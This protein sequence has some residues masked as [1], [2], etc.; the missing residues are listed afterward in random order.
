MR[1]VSAKFIGLK[2][3]YSKSGI[4]TVDIDFTKCKHNI[5]MITGKNGSGKSTLL[6]VLT[7]LPDSPQMYLDHRLGSKEIVY[8]DG[9]N[10]YEINIQYP[11][12]SNGTRLATKAFF[13]E[14]KNNQSVE[15][16]PNGTLGSY[17]DILFNKFNLDANYISL[18]KL[19]M[20]DRGIVDKRPSERKKYVGKMLE[21]VEAYNDIYKTLVKRSSIFKSMINSITAKIDSIGDEQKLTMEINAINTR[22]S[23]LENEK[24]ILESSISASNA[25]VA[26]YDPNNSIQDTYN[27]CIRELKEL[28]SE[29]DNIELSIST[30][31]SKFDIDL[32][33]ENILKKYKL[34]ED[35]KTATL[36]EIELQK[37]K[38]QYTLANR[39]E[40]A[41]QIEI[42]RQKLLTQQSDVDISNL[43][44]SIVEYRKKIFEYEKTFNTI[45]I[46][47][48]EISK[49]EYVLGLNTLN[50]LRNTVLN[51]KSYADNS[52]IIKIC[53]Y[54][55]TEKNPV[56]ELISLNSKLEQNKNS[57]IEY[58][59]ELNYYNGQLSKLDIL[60]SRPSNCDIDTCPF[61]KDAVE[62]SLRNPQDNINRLSALIDECRETIR[63]L[64]LLI[65]NATM[66]NK[67]YTDLQIIIRA[68]KNNSGILNKLPNGT[69]FS[70]IESFLDRV[71]TG[72]QFNDIYD[73]YQYI[74]YAN[75]FELYKNDNKILINL[76]SQYKIYES[77]IDTIND[78]NKEIIDLNNK[79]KD[80]DKKVDE[81][82]NII[83]SKQKEIIDIDNMIETCDIILK[84]LE[85]KKSID[86][87]IKDSEMRI[88]TVSDSIKTIS[89]E[90]EK[91]SNDNNRLIIVNKELQPLQD[92]RDRL[93]F[94][95]NKLDEYNQ[96]LKI[97]TSKY[98]MIQMIKKYSSPTEGIQ[99]I[100]MKL[101][102]DSTLSMANKLLSLLFNGQLEL[103]DYE[104]N[105][106]EFRIPCRN[107]VTSIINDDISSCSSAE[108]SMISMILSFILSYQSSP[109][110][111][112]PTIDEMDEMLDAN[113][114][115]TYPQFLNQVMEILGIDMCI[116]VSHSP[117]MDR[118]DVDIIQ[119]LPATAEIP[120]GNIIYSLV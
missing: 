108:K 13:R 46:K 41:M 49:D 107:N 42:K 72:D 83:L 7:P 118:S 68:I 100:F 89:R 5:V 59:K 70:N 82:N 24:K 101:Y 25:T 66:D 50:D 9:E 33:Y 62:A 37:Q 28:Q 120:K 91:I 40:D 35:L 18:S 47:N 26:V 104:I 38:L 114:R 63:E 81:S 32:T 88:A 106:S 11:I 103:M 73:L 61:I 119:L 84:K 78:L 43:K 60:N 6:N 99:T 92:D 14:T 10:I 95:L 85:R 77:K 3:V 36:Q 52:Q 76:E 67:I 98:N 110:F 74:D 19:S 96:E 30:L 4:D 12:S 39:E 113:N 20:E 64:E 16:N 90:L 21:S 109:I 23:S 93:R 31:S 45:G 44:S 94:S 75:I 1:I 102:M 54:I 69:I 115:S 58:E 80:I 17:K 51:I 112:I 116:M 15:L 56:D 34:F 65:E 105:Q 2:G 117:E 87:S 57:M 55:L 71:K 53:D 97:Y 86:D 29:K 22:I 27:K 111:N 79:I 8:T 48:F